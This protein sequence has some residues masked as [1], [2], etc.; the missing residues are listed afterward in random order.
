MFPPTFIMEN[1]CIFISQLNFTTQISSSE[2]FSTGCLNQ[3]HFQKCVCFPRESSIVCLF[4]KITVDCIEWSDS[5]R[6]DFVPCTWCRC[7]RH[8]M[9]NCRLAQFT[10]HA[11]SQWMLLKGQTVGGL[12]IYYVGAFT[13]MVL[14]CRL[15]Q[16]ICNLKT[17]VDSEWSD[18]RRVKDDCCICFSKEDQNCKQTYL[19]TEGNF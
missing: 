2:V 15:A 4:S 1:E 11:K 10:Y 19:M 7:I 14:R 18:S 17:T 12:T 9:T 6:V 16:F 5:G 13:P 8:M 3:R